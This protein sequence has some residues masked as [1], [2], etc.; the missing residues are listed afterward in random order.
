ML[1]MEQWYPSW[2]RPEHTSN[3]NLVKEAVRRDWVQT[4]HDAGAGGHELNQQ[5]LD[6]VK[7][8]AGYEALPSFDRPNPPKVLGDIDAEWAAMEYPIE[9]G[10]TARGQFA[11]KYAEWNHDLDLKLRQEWESSAGRAPGLW[12][13]VRPYVRHGY[14]YKA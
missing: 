3:W 11:S 10:Y 5:A 4:R 6:T 7:Q 14:D 8:A 13:D 12:E 2:Y 9:Y 1:T